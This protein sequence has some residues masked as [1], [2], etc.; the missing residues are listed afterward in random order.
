MNRAYRDE[1]AKS[2]YF[3][4]LAAIG[5]LPGTVEAIASDNLWRG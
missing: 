2:R 3:L 1:L 5:S 4:G